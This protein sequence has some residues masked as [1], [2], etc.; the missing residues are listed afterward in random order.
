MN[1]VAPVRNETRIN[2]SWASTRMVPSM[3][4]NFGACGCGLAG[5]KGAPHFRIMRPISNYGL[6]S[7]LHISGAIPDCI[8]SSC[9]L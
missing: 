7:A 3:L 8:T 4:A 9:I 1:P 6:Q 5:K 2:G